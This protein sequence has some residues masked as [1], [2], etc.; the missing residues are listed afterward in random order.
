MAARQSNSKYL[1]FRCYLPYEKQTKHRHEDL[2]LNYTSAEGVL[3]YLVHPEQFDQAAA[4]A[5]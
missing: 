5:G 1:H 3:L 2:L 4:Q